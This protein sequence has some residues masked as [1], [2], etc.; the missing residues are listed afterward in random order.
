MQTVIPGDVLL[1]DSH[2][3]FIDE[4]AFTGETF[5]VEKNAGIVAAV[6]L[7]DSEWQR[8]CYHRCC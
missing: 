2:E 4:A 6:T 8:G 5:P 1:L 7:F 3:L